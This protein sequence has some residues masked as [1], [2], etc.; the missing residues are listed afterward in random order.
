MN[1]PKEVWLCDGVNPPVKCDPGDTT[2]WTSVLRAE[3]DK[4]VVVGNRLV[5]THPFYMKPC[6]IFFS[7]PPTAPPR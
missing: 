4:W 7:E 2:G 1:D 5:R 6:P 3:P